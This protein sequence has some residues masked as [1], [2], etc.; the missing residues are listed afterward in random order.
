[1]FEKVKKMFVLLGHY[2]PLPGAQEFNSC[3]AMVAMDEEVE[4]W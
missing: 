4:K 2:P 3:D 1:M